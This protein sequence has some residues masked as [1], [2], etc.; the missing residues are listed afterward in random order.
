MIE[1]L[2]M[3][4]GGHLVDA[5]DIYP[6]SLEYRMHKIETVW[7]GEEAVAI[8]FDGEHEIHREYGNGYHRA[9][10][11]AKTWINEQDEL[12]SEYDLHSVG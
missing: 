5:K 2:A 4:F 7:D 8:I 11:H 6:S 10:A 12:R 9:I 3:V 1:E